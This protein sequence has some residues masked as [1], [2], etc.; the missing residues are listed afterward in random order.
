MFV[1]LFLKNLKRIKKTKI[2]KYN[3][4]RRFEIGQ[5]KWMMLHY[6]V[7]SLFASSVLVVTDSE[8]FSSVYI[9]PFLLDIY[10]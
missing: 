3:N 10:I 7:L 6:D 2:G 5:K 9:A 4:N 1:C 8:E